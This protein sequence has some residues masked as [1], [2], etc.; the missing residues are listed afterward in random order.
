MAPFWKPN[1]PDVAQLIPNANDVKYVSSGGWKHVYSFL[2]S[3]R[4]WALMIIPLPDQSVFS[5][6]SEL[7]EIRTKMRYRIAREVSV[8]MKTSSQSMVKLGPYYDSSVGYFE[9]KI[10]AGD[11]LWFTEEFVEGNLLSELISETSKPSIS[12]LL[13]L[14]ESILDCIGDFKANGLVH[15]DIKPKNIIRE[16]CSKGGS[17]R[18]LDAGVAFDELS[19]RLTTAGRPMG[20]WKYMSPE[21]ISGEHVDWR[22]DLFSLAITVF[23]YAT[24]THPLAI[25]NATVSEIVTSILMRSPRQLKELREDL[26]VKFCNLIG[27]LLRKKPHLRL[28]NLTVIKNSLQAIRGETVL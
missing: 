15:R 20:T 27:E 19:S 8:I 25:G 23:E 17:Y 22:S 28:G 18:L 11:A 16:T 14:L 24:G 12:E 2:Q 4:K 5:D 3:N 9:T 10:G 7:E 13:D 21:Q 1:L 26:P 6:E